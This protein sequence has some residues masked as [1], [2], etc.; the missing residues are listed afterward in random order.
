MPQ[1]RPLLKQDAYSIG[2]FMEKIHAEFGCEPMHSVEATIRLFDTPWLENGT[3]LVLESVNAEILGYGWVRLSSWHRQNVIHLGLFL[4]PAARE[5]DIY[6]PL[7]DEL[8]LN[9]RRLAQQSGID[10]IITYYRSIDPIHPTIISQLGFQRHTVSMLGFKHNLEISDI[11]T[12]PV[13]IAIRPAR[14]PEEKSLINLLGSKAFD[15]PV[16]QGEPVSEIYLDLEM[17]NP[18]FNPEQ[19]IIAETNGE[20]IGY[21]LMFLSKDTDEICYDIGELGV[22]PEWRKRGVGLFLLTTALNW[23]KRKGASRAFIASFS[24]NPV[25]SLYWKLKFRPDPVRTYFFYTRAI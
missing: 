25:I 1:I 17:M 19:F 5:E 18:K 15:D 21:L 20:P 16:N 3:G 12:P 10:E 13:G 11:I 7:T 9:A 8:L 4:G 2:G 14:L 23:M 24:S 22:V 6:R